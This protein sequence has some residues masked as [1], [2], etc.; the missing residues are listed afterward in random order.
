M[1]SS[2]VD[3]KKSP[4]KYVTDM[5][6]DD[7]YLFLFPSVDLRTKR[8]PCSIDGALAGRQH[9]GPYLFGT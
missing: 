7:D 5:N 6:D 3:K 8:Q 1:K 2:G 9:K 4:H